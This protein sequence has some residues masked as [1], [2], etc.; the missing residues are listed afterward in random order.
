M[1]SATSGESSSP[2]R[3]SNF[4]TRDFLR[5]TRLQILTKIFGIFS[6]W[7]SHE[8]SRK[9]A[10]WHNRKVAFLHSLLHLLPLCGAVTLL[11]LRG[12]HFWIGLNSPSS[13]TLQFVAKFHE[14]LMQ[15]SIMEVMF[16]IVR[17][18]AVNG[19]VPLGAL[20]GVVQAP[21]LSYLWSLD[22]LSTFTSANTFQ[23][24]RRVAIAI[25]MPVLLILTALVGPSSAVLMIPEQ[26]L[27][28][29]GRPRLIVYTSSLTRSRGGKIPPEDGDV[30]HPAE[31]GLD[32]GLDM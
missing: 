9:I 10:F 11:V 30:M 7:R 20:S 25:A 29:T 21:Q 24:W 26:G 17:S 8:E 16:C 15:G 18:E 32:R 5:H 23:G 27:P 14:L 2:S 12:I 22:F 1:S 3:P 13:T 6:I 28:N 31:L 4:K 19:Y